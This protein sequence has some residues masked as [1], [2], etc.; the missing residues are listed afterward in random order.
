MFSQNNPLGFLKTYFSFASDGFIIVS[1][2]DKSEMP[3]SS[4]ILFREH[5][6]AVL[7]FF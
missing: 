6:V 1:W 5:A 4:S 7:S 3:S 2:V